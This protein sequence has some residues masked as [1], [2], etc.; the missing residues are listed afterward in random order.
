MWR[1]IMQACNYILFFSILVLIPGCKQ[2][3]KRSKPLATNFFE[4]SSLEAEEQHFKQALQLVNKS[5]AVQ[6]TP[7]ALAHKATLLYQ[8]NDFTGSLALFE[9]TINQKNT[10]DA[11][12]ADI[13]NNYACVLNQLG[14]KDKAR[15]LWEELTTDTHYLTPEVAYFNLG[16]LALVQADVKKAEEHLM[17]AT[18]AAPDYVDAFFYL[19]VTQI[20]L[21]KLQQAQEY[22]KTILSF[23]PEHA[24]AQELLTQV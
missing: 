16:L 1:D 18:E 24:A 20:R 4:Q 11:L 21:G 19:A 9:K 6:P 5:I 8:L 3:K 12:R 17:Q 2:Q 22:L 23:A 14:Q 13:K 10:P 15:Q 7:Q